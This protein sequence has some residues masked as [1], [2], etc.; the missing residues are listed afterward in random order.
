MK[1]YIYYLCFGLL[2]FLIATLVHAGFEMV[3]LATI[4]ND[5]ERYG[6]SFLW[7]HWVVI[8][9]IFSA[10]L[11]FAGTLA[12]FRLGRHFWQILYVEE[13]YGTPRF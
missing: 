5:L 12:G 7:R 8:H 9:Q 11:W 1:R 4:T 3:A 13:R 10:S 6:G 2:G